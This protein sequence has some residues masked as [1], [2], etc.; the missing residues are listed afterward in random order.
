MQ[1][2]A[3]LQA[4]VQ[5]VAL[6]RLQAVV[7]QV[8]HAPV[9]PV[10][11]QAVAQAQTALVQL[12][13]QALMQAQTALVQPVADLAQTA[14]VQSVAD[15]QAGAQAQTALLQPVA[16]QYVVQAQSVTHGTA[17]ALPVAAAQHVTQTAS[18]QLV[19]PLQPVTQDDQGSQAE[20]GKQV[21]TVSG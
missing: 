7:Q 6:Q 10:A 3:D 2:V 17:P 13:F 8:T 11:A 4:A 16:D 21:S 14:L 9:Q 20:L 18:V 5:H 15:L 19:A 1:P 12:A